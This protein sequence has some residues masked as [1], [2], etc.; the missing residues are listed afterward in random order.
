MKNR[1]TRHVNP[2]R[3]GSAEMVSC[4]RELPNLRQRS[5]C[6]DGLRARIDNPDERNTAFQELADLIRITLRGLS[7]GDKTSTARSGTNFA[8]CDRGLAT[9]KFFRSNKGHIGRTQ[10]SVGKYQSHVISIDLANRMVIEI[11]RDNVGNLYHY[12]ACKS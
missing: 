5:I 3:M 1:E 12:F 6:S 11:S 2:G 9:G 4:C 8:E 7:P 10:V